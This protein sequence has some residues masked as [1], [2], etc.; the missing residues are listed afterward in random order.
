MGINSFNLD[1]DVEAFLEGKDNKSAF[2]N[3]CLRRVMEGYEPEAVVI[4]YQLQDLKT[5]LVKLD[6]RHEADRR[7]L[8]ERIEELEDK[9]D[10]M[11][12]HKQEDQRDRYETAKDALDY[13]DIHQRTQPAEFWAAELDCEI[14]ELPEVVGL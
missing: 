1:D 11:R 3:N 9:R 10:R 4:D 14:E 7:S 12:R 6:N 2:V 8:T 5:E 13:Q